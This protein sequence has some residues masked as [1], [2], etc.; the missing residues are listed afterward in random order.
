[1]KIGI[2]GA[3]V[4]EIMPIV[5]AIKELKN[6]SLRQ[7]EY[8][9][10]VYFL[11]ERTSDAGSEDASQSSLAKILASCEGKQLVLAYSKVGKVYSTMTAIIMIERYKCETILF[12]GVAGGISKSVQI[13]DIVLAKHTIQHDIDITGVN[14]QLTFGQVAMP[15]PNGEWVPDTVETPCDSRLLELATQILNAQQPRPNF[16][17]GTIATGDIFC[18]SV[19]KKEE[20]ARKYGFLEREILAI[21]MEGGSVNKVCEKMGVACLVIRSISDDGDGNITEDFGD[22]MYKT[23]LKSAEITVKLLNKI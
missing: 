6:W 16:H 22:F 11:G 12:S 15:A 20:I 18:D 10:N 7:E 14:S 17:V 23:A 5:E 4:G 9:G 3:M 13:G 2:L 19:S 8:A 21:E 1:M